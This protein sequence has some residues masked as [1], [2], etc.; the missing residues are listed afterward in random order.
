MKAVGWL[1]AFLALAPAPVF[2]G[3]GS[4]ADQAA[5]QVSVVTPLGNPVP[6]AR[7][8]I[9]PLT[10]SEGESVCTCPRCRQRRSLEVSPEGLFEARLDPG[11]YGV[12]VRAEGWQP[13]EVKE[14]AVGAGETRALEVRLEP[15][16]TIAGRV[17][18]QEGS[19]LA[20][21]SIQLLSRG[22][23]IPED[24]AV[25]DQDGR[26]QF[27]SL[28]EGAFDIRAELSGYVESTVRDIPTETDDLILVMKDGYAI[29]GRLEGETETL[30]ER[31]RIQ[32]NRGR[33]MRFHSV[34]TIDLDEKKGFLI[35]DLEKGTYSLKATSGDY[36]SDWIEDVEAVEPDKAE[37]VTLTVYRGARISGRV[38][39]RKSGR[40]LSGVSMSLMPSADRRV[41]AFKTTDEKGRY[42][43][44][45]LPS[46]DFL[47]RGRL[48]ADYFSRYR[49]EQSVTLAA[50]EELSGMDFEID[51][52]REVSFSG[53]VADE[54]NQPIAGAELGLHLKSPRESRFRSVSLR[55]VK[56]DEEGRFSFSK[57]LDG[58]LEV[59][60]SARG[61]NFAPGET[62]P[63]TVSSARESLTGLLIQLS[64][65]AALRVEAADESGRSLRGVVVNVGP[66]WMAR[67]Q[68]TLRLSRR[69]LR[70]VTDSRGVA[71]FTN[72]SP[73]QYRIEAV[74]RGF[75]PTEKSFVLKQ[76]E[77]Q[78]TVRLEML[79]ERTLHVLVADLRGDPV[80]GAEISVQ[81]PGFIGLMR[82]HV[83][84]A[85]DS[86]GRSV[87]EG[88]P[89]G[90]LVLKVEAEN[91]G[92]LRGLRVE[93]D[94]AEIEVVLRPAGRITGRLLGPA[95]LAVKEYEMTVRQRLED[96]FDP[97]LAY[98]LNMPRPE[99]L[100]DGRFLIPHLEAGVYTLR[101]KASGLAFKEIEE[102]RVEEGRGTSVGD[103]RLE[104]EGVVLGL[105]VDAD[106]GT[107]IE[108][109][110]VVWKYLVSART[111]HTGGFEL[112][113]LPAGVHALRISA[114]GMRSQRVE[115]VRIAAGD[116]RELDRVELTAMTPAEIE[117]RDR[118]MRTIPTVGVVVG[119][120]GAYTH[121]GGLPIDKV[122]PG[123]AAEKTGLSS[124]DVII[125]IDD[126][127]FLEDPM[128]FMRALSSEP[129]TVIRLTVKRGETGLEEEM[130]LTIENID[131]EEWSKRWQEF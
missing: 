46:G 59:I 103:L 50:G 55:N 54:A 113:N 11:L 23:G 97:A 110:R 83:E 20:G 17:I 5:L 45:P 19:P 99:K 81:R 26:F 116:R 94:Q 58:D 66:D 13:E 42:E 64:A 121:T 93:E 73:A 125:K 127:S 84:A 49:I 111:D 44:G 28:P 1:I 79:P 128:P 4:S 39:D 112:E 53:V 67:S 35:S 98:S 95:G 88:L 16:R 38:L 89:R 102:V 56:T 69:R 51:T 86:T 108:R 126:K 22:A 80:A 33:S 82:A 76:D 109:A 8:N 10:S 3:A 78:K 15:G 6:S 37:P 31:V 77:F 47:L 123:S 129:G 91:Y 106:D 63:V 2:P 90:P 118:A 27:K 72:L 34:N 61:E 52:G 105:V 18:D 32:L 65:G 43:L 87:I 62:E 30:G 68:D 104:T 14:V 29:R 12:E 115:G 119:E 131:M 21:A 96:P 25:S 85:S 60:L 71:E 92:P 48:R 41:L 9:Y 24:E 120:I 114:D 107:P 122:I 74:G 36:L 101:I 117:E 130:D 70:G 75:A 7:V 57:S 40:P 124:G 100:G